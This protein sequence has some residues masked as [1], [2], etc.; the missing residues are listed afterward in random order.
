MLLALTTYTAILT[1]HVMAAIAAF[2]FFF[3]YPVLLAAVRNGGPA[4][5]ALHL[6]LVR[7]HRVVVTPAT[8]ILFAAGIYL[9]MDAELFDRMWVSLPM[10]ITIILL[11][12]TGAYFIPREKKLAAMTGEVDKDY[13]ILSRQV[14]IM[15]NVAALLTLIAVYLMVVKP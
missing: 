3:A 12:L 5:A 4:P 8:V 1:I 10:A 9:A 7:I 14:G 13:E 2:G 15:A 11:G 6:G